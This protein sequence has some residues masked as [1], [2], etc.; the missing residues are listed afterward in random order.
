MSRRM[1]RLVSRFLAPL[2][3]THKLAAYRRG[4]A[5]TWPARKA[6][7]QEFWQA[8]QREQR[9]WRILEIHDQSMGL[10]KRL[11][12]LVL[13]PEGLSRGEIAPMLAETTAH[14]REKRYRTA[15]T[16]GFKRRFRKRMAKRRPRSARRISGRTATPPSSSAARSGSTRPTRRMVSSPSSACRNAWRGPTS[17]WSGRRAIPDI[18]GIPCRT[19][20]NT[21]A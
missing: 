7:L 2:S 9:P 21:R 15:E 13:V 4:W 5:L 1:P 11:D 8:R 12:V 16:Q 18:P 17:P 3:L 6:Q 19:G 14:V 20:R 10:A